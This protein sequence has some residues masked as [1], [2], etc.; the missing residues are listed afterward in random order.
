MLKLACLAHP[1]FF[2]W[3]DPLNQHLAHLDHII[4]PKEVLDLNFA[5]IVKQ[6]FIVR[7]DRVRLPHAQLVTFKVQL[8][9][10]HA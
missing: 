1:D 4:L 5:W 8:E 3:K 6:D 2:V 9:V 7:A 10:A